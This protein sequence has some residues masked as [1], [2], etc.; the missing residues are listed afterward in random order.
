MAKVFFTTC[1]HLVMPLAASEETALQAFLE[2]LNGPEQVVA[3]SLAHAWTSGGGTVRPGKVATRLIAKREGPFTGGS[4]IAA[5][6]ARPARL[7]IARAIMEHH[8][9]GADAWAHWSDELADLQSRGFDPTSKY[10]TIA[11]ANVDD[12]M[13]ARLVTSMR[14]LARLAGA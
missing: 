2:G 3:R 13:L 8:G 14:D 10:P 9:L 12:R 4:I 1:H 6:A 11:L 5:T 7:E